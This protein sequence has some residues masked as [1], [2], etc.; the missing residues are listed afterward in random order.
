ML[1]SESSFQILYSVALH[2]NWFKYFTYPPRY[3]RLQ[4]RLKAKGLE[5]TSRVCGGA[6][7]AQL[8]GVLRVLWQGA[9]G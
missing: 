2:L 6:P 3:A 8:G 5:G 7:L 4:A 1:Y 9:E